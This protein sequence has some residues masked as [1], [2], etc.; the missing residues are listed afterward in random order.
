MELHRLIRHFALGKNA[1]AVAVHQQQ[2]MGVGVTQV[3]IAAQYPVVILFVEGQARLCHQ[4][5]QAGAARSQ[6][7]AVVGIQA[8]AAEAGVQGGEVVQVRKGHRHGHAAGQ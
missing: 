4:A 6:R 3:C 5:R 1:V 2:E 7:Q 8:R